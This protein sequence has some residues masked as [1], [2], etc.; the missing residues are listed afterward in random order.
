[1]NVVKFHGTR[2]ERDD[3]QDMLRDYLPK[4][5]KKNLPALDV[6][7]VPITYFQ[8]ESSEDRDFLRKLNYDYCVVDEGHLLKNAKGLRYKN[9]DR[10]RSRHRLLLTG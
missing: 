4:S 8:K 6:I 2:E 7:L 3:L 5:K 10:F 1:M 9:L